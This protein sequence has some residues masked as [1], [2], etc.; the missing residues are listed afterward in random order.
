MHLCILLESKETRRIFFIE[1]SNAIGIDR[2]RGNGF[3]LKQGRFRYKKE[4][5]YY[6]GGE[7]LKQDAQRSCVCPIARSVQG[8]V[9]WSLGQPGLVEGVPAHVR[10]AGIR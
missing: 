7:A 10:G 8:Q 4:V 5:L 2:T 9:G 6:E 3:K 1:S